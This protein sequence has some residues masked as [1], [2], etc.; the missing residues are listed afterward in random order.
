MSSKTRS[1]ASAELLN[2]I[3]DDVRRSGFPLE[4]HVLNVCSTKNT[5]RMPSLRYEHKGEPRELDL[6]AFFDTIEKKA[7]GKAAPQHT[8]TH[9]IV[10]CKKSEEK[11]WVFFSSPS[12]AFKDQADF[13]KYASDFDPYFSRR[14][15]PPLLS[16]VRPR[17]NNSH[18]ANPTMPRCI[19]YYEAF[20]GTSGLNEIYRAI[21]SVVTYLS[22]THESHL[23]R[24]RETGIYTAFYLP[25]VVL[26][27]YLFEV[28]MQGDQVHV[29]ERQHLQL[30]TFQGGE[31]H[32]IDVVTREHFEQFFNEV[33]AFHTELVSAISH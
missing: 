2:R 26:D 24:E 1:S 18:Y 17:I 9:L 14:G 25:V 20:K 30:R 21:D 31:V 29:L 16:Q 22:Y 6:L 10:E 3:A 27:G 11:P 7:K 23:Q 15:L 28:S 5:G 33:H 32:I 4:V 8:A 19:A 13:L 12:Y